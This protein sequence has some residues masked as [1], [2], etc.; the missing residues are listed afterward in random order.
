MKDIMSLPPVT[1]L[2][3]TPRST[4]NRSLWD[5]SRYVSLHPSAITLSIACDCSGLRLVDEIFNVSTL[6]TALA[7]SSGSSKDR[8]L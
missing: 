1:A 2:A 3:N 4:D 7:N 6:L 8:S 5:K